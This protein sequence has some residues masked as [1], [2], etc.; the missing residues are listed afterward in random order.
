MAL[1]INYFSSAAHTFATDRAINFYLRMYYIIYGLL[2]IISLLPFPVLYLI[3][4]FAYFVI[5]RLIGYR[6]SI[7]LYNLSIAFPERSLDDRKKI[8]KQFYKNLVDTF[9]ETIK[10]L[11]ISEKEF[12]KR[13]V[14]YLDEINALAAKGVNIQFM[15]GHQMNWEYVNWGVSKKLS[16]PFVGIYMKIENKALDK[17]FYRQ[18]EKFGTVLVGAH[19]FRD[20]RHDV[21]NRQYSIG[22]AADQNPGGPTRVYWLYFFNKATP[23]VTGPD[24]GARRNG[25]AIVFVKFIKVKRGYYEFRPGILTED[26]S[27]LKEGEVTLLYRDF[28]EETIREHPDNYL[29][30]HRRWKWEFLEEYKVEWIDTAPPPL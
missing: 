18:R 24:K 17:I 6:K 19:E 21:F 10:L 9:I 29:W 28:L 16:I 23:F 11:S 1:H 12:N 22:L 30:S 27:T 4:D 13:S 2:Y 8:A 14:V 3:S 15:G 26:A 5:Y 25:S 7:V 20:R